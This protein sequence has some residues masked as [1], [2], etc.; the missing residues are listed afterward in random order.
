M[1]N[2]ELCGCLQTKVIRLGHEQLWCT[3]MY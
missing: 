2:K 3:Y 1:L